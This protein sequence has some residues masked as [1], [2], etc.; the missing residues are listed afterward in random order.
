MKRM[1]ILIAMVVLLSSVAAPAAM[2]Y[3]PTPYLQ[4][5]DSPFSGLSFISFYLEDFEDGLMNTPGVSVTGGSIYQPTY[6]GANCDSVDADDGT[7]DGDNTGFLGNSW[8]APGEPGVTFTFDFDAG[9]LGLLPTHVGIVWTDGYGET[10]FEAFNSGG[11]SLGT[12]GPVV[13]GV[14]G[15][16]TGETDEDRFFGVSDLGG[17]GRITI[18]T[19]PPT[20]G[21]EVDHLQYGVVP[22]PGAV[23]LGMLGLGVAGWKL[24]KFA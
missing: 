20:S 23:L 2:W 9:V 3:G 17:I 1:I 7:I 8:W 24:R 14:S 11:V 15:Q 6:S 21:V 13:L 10:T 5:S 4:F 22:V 19:G 16:Y 18:T 12:I